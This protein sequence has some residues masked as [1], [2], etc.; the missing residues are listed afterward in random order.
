MPDHT[1]THTDTPY[2]RTPQANSLRFICVDF[3][4]FSSLASSLHLRLLLFLLLRSKYFLTL[5]KQAAC[6][7]IPSCFLCCTCCC[8]YA[9]AVAALILCFLLRTQSSRRLNRNFHAW[10]PLP[11]ASCQAAYPFTNELAGQ[12]DR[13]RQGRKESQWRRLHLIIKTPPQRANY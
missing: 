2:T 8:C 5:G 7:G 9:A 6:L 1:H 3:V 13:R 11:A 10:R 12:K 4:A